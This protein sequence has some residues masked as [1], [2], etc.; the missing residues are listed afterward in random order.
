MS[1]AELL[2]RIN[3]ATAPAVINGGFKYM[4]DPFGNY[5]NFPAGEIMSKLDWCAAIAADYMEDKNIFRAVFFHKAED[6]S[7]EQYAD[8]KKK[9]IVTPQE[10]LYFALEKGKSPEIID[11][12][13]TLN[14]IRIE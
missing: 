1:K 5:I 10:P 7:F 6:T 11:G 8:G 2:N 3:K 13:E 14:L 9:L 12:S 4:R